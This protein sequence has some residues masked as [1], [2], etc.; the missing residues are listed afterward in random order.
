MS[1][2]MVCLI[3]GLALLIHETGHF[4]MARLA[5]IPVERFSVGFGPKLWGFRKAG[6][7]FCLSLIPLGGYVLP[8]LE[9]Q[10]EFFRISPFKRILFALG[11]PIANILSVIPAMAA[12]N[13]ATKGFSAAGVFFHPFLQSMAYISKI[14]GSLPL[15]FQQP[16]NISGVVGI[17]SQG[18][19]IVGS[20]AGVFALFAFLSVNFAV[21]NLL[22]VPAL[23]GG[24]ILLTVM[25]KVSPGWRK[26]RM[27]LALLGWLFLICIMVY[28]TSRDISRLLG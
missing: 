4:I 15:I 12:F 11:G 9:S 2:V 23:D 3:I 10:D 28:A 14:L 5:N 6:T 17:V 16:Q 27:P 26:A 21:L 19:Q 25:E 18:S 13:V 24:Q 20:A 1:Y 22:P 8:K 7:E